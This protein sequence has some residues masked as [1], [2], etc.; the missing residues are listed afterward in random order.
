MLKKYGLLIVVGVVVISIAVYF[1]TTS[2]KSKPVASSSWNEE[3][4]LMFAKLLEQ[5][6][7]L[8]DMVND[9][10]TIQCLVKVFSSN[11]TYEQSVDMVNQGIDPNNLELFVNCI[12]LHGLVSVLQKRRPDIVSKRC[13]KCIVLLAVQEAKGNKLATI[14]LVSNDDTV[15][16]YLDTCL[17]N[18]CS[19]DSSNPIIDHPNSPLSPPAPTPSPPKPSS[20]PKPPILPPILPPSSGPHISPSH[21][22]SQ[23][24]YTL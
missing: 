7:I 12:P 22:H 10:D 16:K 14:K 6:P 21:N 19:E 1:Y 11:Y 18:G 3:R 2:R 15:N 5:K 8:K 13:I 20:P 4:K 24:L 17:K 9:N 23:L